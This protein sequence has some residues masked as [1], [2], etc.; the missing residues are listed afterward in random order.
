M[1]ETTVD[2]VEGETFLYYCTSEK[3]FRNRLRKQ[4]EQYPDEIEVRYDDGTTLDVKLPI[5]WFREPKPPIKRNPMTEEQRA[6]AIARLQKA[7]NVEVS[8]SER[9]NID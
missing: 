9:G 2:R 4:M 1:Y 7:K 5:S 6:A 3:K 8:L